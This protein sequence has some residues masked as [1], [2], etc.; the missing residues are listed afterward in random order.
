VTPATLILRY[1]GFAALAT[2]ANLAVQRAVLA[3]AAPPAGLA[4][5]MAAGTAVGLVAKYLLDKRWIFRD[6]ETG[7]GAHGRKFLRYTATGVLTTLIFWGTET[8]FW[9][10]WQTALLRELGAIIGLAIG[11][12]LKYR[13]DRRY[14]FASA[15][16]GQ[17]GAA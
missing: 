6:I 17:R 13:F 16:T 11:Y 15:P 4:L 7:L 8:A 10:L 14:V 3:L 5:A 12:A 2:L 9:L 1:A